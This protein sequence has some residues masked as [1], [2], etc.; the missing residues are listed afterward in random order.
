MWA[1]CFLYTSGKQINLSA[2]HKHSWYL[3]KNCE[4]LGYS[5]SE[6]NI[7]AAIARYHRKTLPKKRHESWQIL[8]SREDKEM[9]LDMS[10]ILRLAS[11]LDKRPIPVISSVKLTFSD[12]CIILK[13]NTFDSKNKP[14][15]E[16]WSLRSCY[17]ILR[18]IKGFELKV[19]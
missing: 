9:A 2:Y 8:V 1:S 13:L 7:I 15:L 6:K 16:K 10:L 3:I 5:L 12:N 4:L 14:L 17:G 18:E 19:I 11:S